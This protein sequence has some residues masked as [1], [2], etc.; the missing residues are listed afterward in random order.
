MRATNRILGLGGLPRL[1]KAGKGSHGGS[2]WREG[3]RGQDAVVEVPVGTLIWKLTDLG[4]KLLPAEIYS[5]HSQLATASE[6]SPGQHLRQGLPE[7]ISAVANSL[8]SHNNETESEKAAPVRHWLQPPLDSD[9]PAGSKAH[10][11]GPGT[12]NDQHLQPGQ[13]TSSSHLA[14]SRTVASPQRA[15]RRLF[16]HMP[17]DPQAVN[18]PVTCC[19]SPSASW[20]KDGFTTLTVDRSIS[21]AIH[22]NN[23]ADDAWHVN[24]LGCHQ[25]SASVASYSS[26]SAATLPHSSTS[27]ATAQYSP[28]R[29]PSRT[30]PESLNTSHQRDRDELYRAMLSGSY[31]LTDKQKQQ[32]WLSGSLD[33]NWVVCSETEYKQHWELMTHGGDTDADPLDAD[34]HD[35]LYADTSPIPDAERWYSHRQVGQDAQQGMYCCASCMD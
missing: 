26:T 2:Q 5:S 3:G 24:N 28:F 9:A 25:P 29:T 27:A 35:Q 21:S 14:P 8:G 30:N 18:S 15:R 34:P 17:D 32:L 6:C 4:G 13:L 12:S 33:V 7:S 10:V 16:D 1:V 31:R 20:V 11:L 19:S 22:V 23:H